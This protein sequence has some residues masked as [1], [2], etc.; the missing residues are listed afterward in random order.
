MNFE[1]VETEILVAEIAARDQKDPNE[2]A[3]RIAANR[4][5][6]NYDFG[7]Q[8]SGKGIWVFAGPCRSWKREVSLLEAVHDRNGVE[9]F[10]THDYIEFTVTFADS[11]SARVVDVSA[12]NGSIV[13]G[14]LSRPLACLD[15]EEEAPS[16]LASCE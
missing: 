2:K 4:A 6:A 8:V 12:L 16:Q 15:G 7:R 13:V 11:H 5:F 14:G 3:R 9:I 10:S 1:E